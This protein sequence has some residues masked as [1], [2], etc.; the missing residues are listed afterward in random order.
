[1][2]LIQTFVRRM[3]G[4]KRKVIHGQIF[5]KSSKSLALPLVSKNLGR[6]KRVE[7]VNRPSRTLQN[8]YIASWNEN[9]G[10]ENSNGN[11]EGPNFDICFS[12]CTEGPHKGL[13]VVESMNIT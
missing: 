8:G 7:K 5:A 13:Y 1:M 3:K 11:T 12:N 9:E 6:L 2:L 10:H 4:R